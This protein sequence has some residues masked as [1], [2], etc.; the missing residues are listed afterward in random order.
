MYFKNAATRK[1]CNSVYE[2]W[3]DMIEDFMLRIP[4]VI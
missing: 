2:Q 4:A 1:D 3:Q